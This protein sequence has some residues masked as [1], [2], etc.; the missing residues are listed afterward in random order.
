MRARD[1]R[2]ARFRPAGRARAH[3]PRAPRR[4]RLTSSSALLRQRILVAIDCVSTTRILTRA[5]S[6]SAC[7]S[8]TPSISLTDRLVLRHAR[9]EEFLDA[10]QTL[11]DVFR[12]AGDTAGVEG[13][14]RQLR[15]RLAD[16][17]RRDDAHRVADLDELAR[18][19]IAPVA[20]PADAVR[21][22]GTAATDRQYTC[23]T[24]AAIIAS[25]VSSSSSDADGDLLEARHLTRQRPPRQRGCGTARSCP[26]C[27]SR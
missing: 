21:R 23:W 22:A 24:P 27:R 1:L 7:S 16:G 2:L 13:T 26:C 6:S 25:T 5:D 18:R 9:L 10:R 8:T 14:H 19:Q 20:Q 17:L 4:H 12:R 11:G 3:R 15:A